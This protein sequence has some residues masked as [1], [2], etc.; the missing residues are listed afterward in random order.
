MTQRPPIRPIE[1]C[2]EFQATSPLP[3]ATLAKRLFGATHV[4]DG[5]TEH[6]ANERTRYMLLDADDS[7]PVHLVL[8]H[9]G[10]LTAAKALLADHMDVLE[11]GTWRRQPVRLDDATH[12]VTYTYATS[13]NDIT[14]T[15]AFTFTHTPTWTLVMKHILQQLDDE[16]ARPEDA[17]ESRIRIL[18]VLPV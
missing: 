15:E 3:Y 1:V 6:V 12:V 7:R 8:R 14:R 18:S 13:Y 17:D 10:T 4:A 2:W 5:Y 11:R 9:T 16:I